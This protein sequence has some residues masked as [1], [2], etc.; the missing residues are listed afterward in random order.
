M[1]L[2][3]A[4]HLIKELNKIG[5]EKTREIQILVMEQRTA[6]NIEDVVAEIKRNSGVGY[7]DADGDYVPPMI[8]TQEVIDI[9][10][11]MISN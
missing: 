7:K 3:D 6:Y 5:W 1:R 2:I 9:V 10:T 8:K 4:D 11:K